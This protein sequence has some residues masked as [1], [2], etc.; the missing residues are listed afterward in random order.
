[1][2]EAMPGHYVQF[3]FA[4]AVEP[5][6]GGCCAPYYGSGPYIEGWAQYA[7]QTMLEQGFLNHSPE[8]ELTFAKQQL[9]VIAN[10]ILD[11]RLRCWI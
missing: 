2:H 8:L 6:P 9:R 4:N 10:A 1:M 5:K 11:V 7:E 3:E